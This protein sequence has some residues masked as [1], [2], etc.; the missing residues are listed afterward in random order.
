MKYYAARLAGKFADHESALESVGFLPDAA[1]LI[2]ANAMVNGSDN[3][4]AN[5]GDG[6]GVVLT[7]SDDGGTLLWQALLGQATDNPDE[8]VEVAKQLAA[9]LNDGSTVSVFEWTLPPST[10]SH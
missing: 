9:Q 5:L 4:V 10:Q 2:I 8:A 1:R 7:R 6:K 3:V